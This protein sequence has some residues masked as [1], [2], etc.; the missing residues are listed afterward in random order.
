[1]SSTRLEE[2]SHRE[3]E[4]LPEPSAATGG[5]LLLVDDT[6]Q[7]L[8]VLSALLQPY[9]HV[10]A[11]TSGERALQAVAVRVPD[12]VLL[13][14][15][16]PGMDGFEV[17]RRLRAIE[18]MAEVPVIFVTAATD[19]VDEL[20]GFE[21]GAA[22]Y[23]HKPISPAVVLSRVRV[24]LEARAARQMLKH[25]NARLVS[26]VAEG[27]QALEQ[28]QKQLVQSEKLA[29]MGMLAAGVAHEINNPITF[30][31]ANLSALGEYLPGIF[32]VVEAYGA[33]EAKLGGDAFAEVRGVMADVDY[34]F[35]S[36]DTVGLL[37]QTREGT[38]R[39]RTI[40]RDL[41]G[42]SRSD[43]ED[44][45]WSDLHQ[46]LDATLNIARNEF[47][48]H[49]TI[50]KDYGALPPV[51]CLSSRLSQVFLNLIVNAA[52]AIEGH[53]EITLSTEQFDA[54]HVRVRVTDTGA[55][56]SPEVQARIFEPFF[57]TK[58]SGKGTGLGLPTV[59]KIVERHGGRLEVTS[60]L[61]QGTTFSVT[62]PI[63]NE[64]S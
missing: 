37:T 13:D 41:K 16:M 52:Q 12:L 29:A 61:G 53:G 38:E 55:G 18:A 6:P 9:Y 22:D 36:K 47:K 63:G 32:K 45:Q 3:G 14:V 44:W 10:R 62:L 34:P 43:D 26:K 31:D 23:V 5:S 30:I 35:I 33:V 19:E 40:V 21:A 59:L 24:Q 60:V 39:V 25:T 64:P 28:A 7:N 20:R 15:M 42:F 54:G 51:F 49:C 48:Y 58:P 4:A 8:A 2:D 50:R 57:T 27:T 17:L 1:M 56:M 46:C 11:V